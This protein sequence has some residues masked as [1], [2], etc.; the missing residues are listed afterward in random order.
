MKVVY[1]ELLNSQESADLG[2]D[3]EK[4]TTAEL[5]T[6]LKTA[7]ETVV[8]AVMGGYPISY[9]PPSFVILASRSVSR[10]QEAR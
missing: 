4:M 2:T 5:E 3:E 1:E 9:L 6:A 7:K 10:L 8:K